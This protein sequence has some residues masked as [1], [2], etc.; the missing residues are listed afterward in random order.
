M[1]FV[2]RVI[3]SPNDAKAAPD[4]Y[5]SHHNRTNYEASN[6]GYQRHVLILPL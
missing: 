5:R 1:L 6:E 3:F 2:T 4:N